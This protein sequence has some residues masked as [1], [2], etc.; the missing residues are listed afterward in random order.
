MAA[1]SKRAVRQFVT[2]ALT[3]G[4]GSTW[5]EASVVY[6]QFG[7]GD[8]DGRLHKGWV[9]GVP[10]SRA[11]QDRQVPAVGVLSETVLGIRWAFNI[12][13]QR[14]L[15]SFDE[16]LDAEQEIV[17]ILTANRQAPDLHLV[18]VS[19]ATP[20]DDQG[21]LFGQLVYKA[22]HHRPLQ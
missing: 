18:H 9:V 6:E 2:A 5:R 22:L 17:T 13:A 11:L 10:E 20:V 15:A 7:T 21:W 3:A 14:Q 8:G 19:S 1:Y 12:A 4:L 16:A